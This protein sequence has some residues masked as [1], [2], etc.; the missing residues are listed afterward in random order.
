[1][2]LLYSAAKAIIPFHS[3]NVLRAYTGEFWIACTHCTP[4]PRQLLALGNIVLRAYAEKLNSCTSAFL[5]ALPTPVKSS[6][7]DYRKTIP[8]HNVSALR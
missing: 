1:M 5:A 4:Q 7:Y 2:C 6:A 8:R 3:G